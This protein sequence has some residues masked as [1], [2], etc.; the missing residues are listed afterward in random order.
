MG[1]PS[2]GKG[3]GKDAGL[4]DKNGCCRNV[5]GDLSLFLNRLNYAKCKTKKTSKE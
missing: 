1:A 2:K 5:R 3:V 4:S